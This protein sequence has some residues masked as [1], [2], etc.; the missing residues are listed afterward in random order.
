MLHPVE[1]FFCF[2]PLTKQTKRPGPPVLFTPRLMPGGMP[3]IRSS[4]PLAGPPF[5]FFAYPQEIEK[6]DRAR[7][8]DQ[9]RAAGRQPFYCPPPRDKSRFSESAE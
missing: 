5:P 1:P 3:R 8:G 2:T 9:R 6:V 7:I 4:D